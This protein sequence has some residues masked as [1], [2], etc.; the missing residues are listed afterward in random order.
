MSK[1]DN[2]NRNAE[3]SEEANSNMIDGIINNFP[4]PPVPVARYLNIGGSK[5]VCI[6]STAKNVIPLKNARQ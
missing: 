4:P 1:R 6:T 2:P 5:D 3:L